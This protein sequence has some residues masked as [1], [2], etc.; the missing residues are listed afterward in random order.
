MDKRDRVNIGW[1]ELKEKVQGILK[2]R[3]KVGDAGGKRKWWNLKC[4]ESK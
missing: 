1:V 4:K 3:Q 2:E